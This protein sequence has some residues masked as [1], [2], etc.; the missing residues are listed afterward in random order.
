MFAVAIVAC[1]LYVERLRATHRFY[2]DRFELFAEEEE[3]ALAAAK[4]PVDVCGMMPAEDNENI[5]RFIH[6]LDF[7][8]AAH[9]AGLKRKYERAA[10][11]P[12][13]SVTPDPPEPE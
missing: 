4:A 2:R 1:F 7:R 12:W 10:R 8:L 6:D 11:Y 3:I 9:Y 5:A 13:L